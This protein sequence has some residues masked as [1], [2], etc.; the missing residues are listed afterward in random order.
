MPTGGGSENNPGDCFPGECLPGEVLAV[1]ALYPASD[2]AAIGKA[3]GMLELQKALN[4]ARRRGRMAGLR[5]AEPGP[6]ALEDLPVDQPGELRDFVAQ[7]D[8]LDQ[9]RPE[10][11]ILRACALPLARRSLALL[12]P[13]GTMIHRRPGI[14]GFRPEACR[15]LHPMAKETGRNPQHFNAMGLSRSEPHRVRPTPASLRAGAIT[16]KGRVSVDGLAQP[17]RAGGVRSGPAAAGR[18]AHAA[19]LIARAAGPEDQ[20]G[21]PRCQP[22]TGRADP[23]G[24]GSCGAGCHPR[25][26]PPT[27]PGS[28]PPSM[29][30]PGRFRRAP[31]GR[32]LRRAIG[33]GSPSQERSARRPRHVLRK[34]GPGPVRRRPGRRDGRGEHPVPSPVMRRQRWGGAGALLRQHHSRR[35]E[36][37]GRRHLSQDDVGVPRRHRAWCQVGSSGQPLGRHPR[38]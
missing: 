22:A 25:S 33:E 31:P 5:R 26:P 14:A 37:P 15:T 20:P 8:H 6:L 13:A 35:R 12:W 16:R 7:I 32:H 34:A 9:A 24:R 2:D 18:S 36:Q 1:R 10:K 4:Q 19:G 27:E 38:R 17:R 28:A 23:S 30:Q 3:I 21:A 29:I 11:V